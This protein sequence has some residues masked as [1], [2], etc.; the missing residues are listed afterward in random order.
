MIIYPRQETKL[1]NSRQTLTTPSF[2][3]F[4]MDYRYALIVRYLKNINT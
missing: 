3:G 2:G 4:L 1:Y